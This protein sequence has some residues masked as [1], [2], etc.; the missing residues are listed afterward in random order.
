MASTAVIQKH[1]S[2]L[3]ADQLR[4]DGFELILYWRSIARRKWW[5][6][7]LALLF[8]AAAAVILSFVTPIYRATVTV[9]IE[10]NRAKLVS[11]E[12]VYSGVSPNR[13]HYQTQAEMLK[14]PALAAAIIEKLR[15]TTHP[16][17]DP[18][19]QKQTFLTRFSLP[20]RSKP[21]TVEWT[22][23]RVQAAVLAD[24]LRRITVAPVR[25][26]QLV[27]V[28]FDSADRG[29]AAKVANTIADMY[30][31][32]DIEVRSRI[33]QRATEWLSSQ[34]AV[35]KQNLEESELALQQFREREGLVNTRG[36]AQSGAV[37]QIEGFSRALSDARQQRIEA[38]TNYNQIKAA[39]GNIEAQPIVLRHSLVARLKG[40]E[41]AAES[42]LAALSQRYG[43]QN[44]RLIQADED[45]KQ[46]RENTRR[47]IAEVIAS[48][49]KE[50]EVAG[51]NERA[52]E[53]ALGG[54]R[55]TVQDINRKE[56][57]LES[58]ERNIATNRQIYERFMSRYKET[59][60]AA[61][62]Q[63]SVVARVI[64]PAIPPGSAYTPQ[65]ERTVLIA[66]V[67][68]IVLGSII[69]LLLERVDRAIKS[70]DDVEEKLGLPTLAVLPLLPGDAGRFVGR[71][72]LE[73]PKSVF[74]ETIRTVR[75]S[76]L[77][78]AI[79]A[80]S[81]I[82]LV[83]SSVPGEGKTAF[84]INLALAHAQTK[85]VLLIEADLRRPSV[86]EQLGLDETKPGLSSLF[87]G[88][89][90]FADCLQRVEG[91]SLYVLP[92]GPATGNA[93]ELLS[94]ERFKHMLSRIS[95]ACE[96]V[97]LDSPPIHLVSDAVVLSTLA[98]GVLFV[99]KANSTPYPVAR[100]CIH[101]LQGAGAT[102]V[103]VALNQLDFRKADRYYGA[104]TS[105]AEEYGGYHTKP[106]PAS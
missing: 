43:P 41:A 87:S 53:R 65:T 11:I 8:A 71:H 101:T 61:D 36:L 42:R 80:P 89:A 78:S 40:L 55:G 27:K 33:T 31:E 75:T 47:G 2:N 79:D 50:Y 32:A 70:G 10:Q 92:S 48:F 24:F 13:E 99:V 94:S 14:S 106:V 59:R 3:G 54:A 67:L 81:K 7:G 77:L 85:K 56:F 69:A 34:L 103:G 104:Y 52:V 38:E 1:Y 84:A 17:F 37:R 12:E 9:L 63:S 64:D 98:T 86:V 102:V 74:S 49:T 21:D 5:I 22:E 28:S 25:L 20:E 46:A 66:F 76:I 35:L 6:L 39:K 93:S 30:I 73:E 96:I 91:S 62:T 90:S 29:L 57:Q 95:A 16:E 83:T 15:L 100:R 60:A 44:V 97:I 4:P 51:A 23:E 45:L 18:R 88:T 19:Q 26:S 68:S 82:L 58:L 105:Y 72:Y